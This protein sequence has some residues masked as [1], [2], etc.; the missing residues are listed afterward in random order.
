MRTDF[1]RVFFKGVVC[2][3]G[4]EDWVHISENNGFKICGEKNSRSFFFFFMQ[5]DN[6]ILVYIMYGYTKHL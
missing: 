3:N 5:S 1:K 6:I 4:D 2:K